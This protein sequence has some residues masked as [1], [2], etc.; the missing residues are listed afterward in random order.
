MASFYTD[1]AELGVDLADRSNPIASISFD[2]LSLDLFWPTGGLDCE[3]Q[4]PARDSIFGSLPAPYAP[5]APPG[6]GV[7]AEG[8][9]LDWYNQ[10]H[11]I[12]QL[13]ELGFVLGETIQT[14]QVWNGYS[15]PKNLAEIVETGTE[16]IALTG[17]FGT[18]PLDVGAYIETT[19]TLTVDVD[20]PARIAATYTW[21]FGVDDMPVL[22]VT[23]DR[24][25]VFAYEPQRPI[26]EELIWLTDIL[27][28]YNGTEQRIAL[29]DIPRQ[30]FQYNY[31]M[32][33][34]VERQNAI[35]ALY[36][37]M[38]RGF[39]VP[40]W[41]DMKPLLSDI[42]AGVFSIP[43]N[44]SIADFRVGG[45]AILWNAYDDFDVVA[46]TAVN[47]LS[48][49]ILRETTLAHL[50]I[51]TLVIPM[52]VVF[53]EDTARVSRTG[54]GYHTLGMRW[55]SSEYKDLSSDAGLTMYKSM[56]VFI[57]TNFLGSDTREEPFGG[58]A[59]F[60][61]TNVGIFSV[62]RKSFPKLDFK[63]RWEPETAAEV[64]ALRLLIH[65]LKGRQRSFWL[66]TYRIDFTLTEAIA[67]ADTV[68]SVERSGYPRYLDLDEPVKHIAIMLKNGTTYY[69][70][71]T[72]ASDTGVID[73]L[74]IDANLGTT[75]QIADVARISYLVRCRLNTDTVRIDHTG[76]GRATCEVP[77]RGVL[78]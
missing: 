71:I 51:D 37:N 65:A 16:G 3:S 18:P 39:A 2:Q 59:D 48:L 76:L 46:I 8:F 53:A 19:Y 58:S 74:T 4:E 72:N 67:A 35:N 40:V 24:A 11:V 47:P 78:I 41:T 7:Y 42:S 14:I 9:E 64:W 30:V 10:I 6:A 36:G 68:L 25:V 45:T 20:G 55:R 32:I 27:E 66:P 26:S 5:L 44:T 31:Q 73:E 70:E 23:G 28:S 38:G 61:D 69:R 12:P 57:D 15:I 22:T 50:A 21:D 33:D 49:D 52:Q 77:V 75:I 63:K 62:I 43:V 34:G 13:L 17:G 29:R 60:L 1:P 54:S 56:P